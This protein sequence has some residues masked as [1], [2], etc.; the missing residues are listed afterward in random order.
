MWNKHFSQLLVADDSTLHTNM[1]L[2]ELLNAATPPVPISAQGATQYCPEDGRVYEIRQVPL[3]HGGR[4]ITFTDISNLIKREIALENA[5]KDAERAN[6]SKTR[7][8]ASAS[9]DLRQPIHALGLFFEELSER[10][11]DTDT[12]QLIDQIEDSIAAI[13]SMLNALL[14]VSKLDAGLVKPEWQ[15]CLLADIFTRLNAEFQPLAQENRNAIRFRLCDYWVQTDPAML[16]RML[17]NLIGNALRYTTSGRVLVGARL[18]SDQVEIQVIDTG[19]GIPPDQLVEV[20]T[21]FHQL[22]NPAWAG[23]CQASRTLATSPDFGA[24]QPRQRL[25]F[26]DKHTYDGQAYSCRHGTRKQ[27]PAGNG[28]LAGQAC[29]VAR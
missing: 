19:Q 16:E 18:R 29:A 4:V 28:S 8:L 3:A 24:V 25:L 27:A 22:H 13:N 7:F 17:R 20:F 23:H 9:H 11:R 21:D 26:F 14:D 2:A 1:Q 6:A 5:R 10:V 12:A 15:P